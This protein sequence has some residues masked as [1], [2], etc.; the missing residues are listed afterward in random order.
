MR[1][2]AEHRIYLGKGNVP[3]LSFFYNILVWFGL[4]WCVDM[5]AHECTHSCTHAHMP[6][7]DSSSYLT[8]K[9]GPSFP[10]PQGLGEGCCPGLG[11]LEVPSQG[12]GSAA[13][14]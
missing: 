11:G 1:E 13:V 10:C 4:V 8:C 12:T 5:H 2:K 7:N 6:G 9:V 14:G 3:F